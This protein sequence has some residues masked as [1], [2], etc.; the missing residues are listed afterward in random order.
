MEKPPEG[1]SFSKTP[2][3]PKPED[4]EG[5]AFAPV[6]ELGHVYGFGCTE[7]TIKQLTEDVVCCQECGRQARYTTIKRWSEAQWLQD[8]YYTLIAGTPATQAIYEW[9]QY[10]DAFKPIWTKAEKYEPQQ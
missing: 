5:F 2:D 10:T 6:C 8:Y 7:L 1:C 4:V 3:M 9:R